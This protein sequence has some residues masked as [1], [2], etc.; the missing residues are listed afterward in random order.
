[1][2][3]I[4]LIKSKG[5]DKRLEG[6]SIG[7]FNSMINAALVDRFLF[8][9]YGKQKFNI[10]KAKF[11]YTRRKTVFSHRKFGV[12]LLSDTFFHLRFKENNVIDKELYSY[13]NTLEISDVAGLNGSFRC[14]VVNQF[15][16]EFS[17]VAELK[18][19]GKHSFFR[20]LTNL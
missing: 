14:R 9:N 11:L 4:F 6:P 19:M 2:F 10:P 7:D 20:Y 1:M 17:K 13:N 15:G 3:S 5:N 18:V 12:T 16:S 8:V